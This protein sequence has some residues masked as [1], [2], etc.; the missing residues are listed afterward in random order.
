MSDSANVVVLMLIVVIVI[1]WSEVRWS[2][3]LDCYSLW[4]RLRDRL[5]AEVLLEKTLGRV[6]VGCAVGCVRTSSRTGGNLWDGERR[7]SVVGE[8][9]EWAAD[10]DVGELFGVWRNVWGV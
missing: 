2:R 10:A 3:N 6:G 9:A 1:L 7:I 8:R 5:N 4:R